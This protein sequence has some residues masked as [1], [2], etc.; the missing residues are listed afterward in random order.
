MVP[1]GSPFNPANGALGSPRQE[2]F[3]RVN[4]AAR[5]GWGL[6]WCG[7]VEKTHVHC[8]AEGSLCLP[9]PEAIL[10]PPGQWNHQGVV[11]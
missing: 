3:V 6:R 5:L 1:W 10:W 8:L 4:R 2:G 7:E 11:A 9:P